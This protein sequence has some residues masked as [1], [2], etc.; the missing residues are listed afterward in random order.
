V[1]E[2]VAL[3]RQVIKEAFDQHNVR[4]LKGDWTS[5]DPTI[6]RKLAEYGRSGVPL[7]LMYA[8]PTGTASVLPQLLTE[9][10]VL[11]SVEGL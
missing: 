7:Y 6:T 5:E 1:N 8:S 11:Q 9:N 10:I 4:Y 2:A 3:N